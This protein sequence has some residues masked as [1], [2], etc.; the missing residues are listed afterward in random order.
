MAGLGDAYCEE[1]E[2]TA[3]GPFALA[4]ADPERLV[5]HRRGARV[6]AGAPARRPTRRR[7]SRTA[8]GFPP[9]RIRTRPA[10]R[11]TH[12]G[13]LLAIAEPRGAEL[14]PVVVFAA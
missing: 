4:D 5:P 10:L 12:G 3:I 1:L 8:C 14:Q 9:A 13:E 11:L 2:R 6:P 7:G